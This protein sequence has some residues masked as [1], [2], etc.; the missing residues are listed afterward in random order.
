LRNEHE[1]SIGKHFAGRGS[2]V[3]GTDAL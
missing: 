3:A 1:K 2:R